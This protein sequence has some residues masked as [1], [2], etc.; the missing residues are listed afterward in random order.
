VCLVNG[1][2]QTIPV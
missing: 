2:A 1:G